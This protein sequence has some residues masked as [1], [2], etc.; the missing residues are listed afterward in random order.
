MID[1]PFH[2]T[3]EEFIL[4]G[5]TLKKSNVFPHTTPVMSDLCM[6]KTLLGKSHA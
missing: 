2:A 3:S 1:K 4:E 5:F 6:S